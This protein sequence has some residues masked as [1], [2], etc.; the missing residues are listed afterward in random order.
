MNRRAVLAGFSTAVLSGGGAQTEVPES[1]VMGLFRTWKAAFGL[2]EGSALWGWT[3]AERAP[4]QARETEL[5]RQLVQTPARDALDVC[6]KLTA[7]TC[8]GQQFADDGGTLSDT[9]L[10]EARMIV[11]RK[12]FS[13]STSNDSGYTKPDMESDHDQPYHPP[14]CPAPDHR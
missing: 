4:F 11:Q 9:I 3:E 8:D 6:A 5:V 12:G 7:F 13:I 1:A 2:A 10:R 14:R